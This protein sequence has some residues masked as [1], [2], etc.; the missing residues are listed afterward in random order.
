MELIALQRAA[1]DQ[2]ATSAVLVE[3]PEETEVMVSPTLI[4]EE[5]VAEVVVGPSKTLRYRKPRLAKMVEVTVPP[6]LAVLAVPWVKT[7]EMVMASFCFG[8][9]GDTICTFT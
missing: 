2:A 9:K 1:V 4:T 8:T 6:E 7:A 3:D 5:A